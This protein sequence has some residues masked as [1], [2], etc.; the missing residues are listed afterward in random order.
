[1]FVV[2]EPVPCRRRFAERLRRE[3]AVRCVRVPV[4]GGASFFRLVTPYCGGIPWQAVRRAAGKLF[5]LLPETPSMP[6]DELPRVFVPRQF[7]LL[8]TTQTAAALLC[9]NAPVAS[10]GVLDPRGALCGH[11]AC[12][13]SAARDVRIVTDHPERFRQDV[14]SAMRERGAAMTVERDRALLRG[15]RVLVCENADD[16]PGGADAVFCMRQS[17]S[18]TDTVYLSGFTLPDAYRS[19]LPKGT[20]PFLFAAALYELCGVRALGMC[21]FSGFHA[22]MQVRAI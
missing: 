18:R 3:R 21:R 11:T 17:A 1:M 14:Y 10:L 7:P 12:L 13:L 5:V 9:E 8:C 15:C 19:L 20:D 4:P 2:I 16:A 6:K 22:G